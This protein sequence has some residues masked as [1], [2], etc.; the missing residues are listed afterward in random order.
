MMMWIIKKCQEKSL[1]I[2][3]D[4]YDW[5]QKMWF[6]KINISDKK[7]IGDCHRSIVVTR[8]RKNLY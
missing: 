8:R 3:S 7:N 1:V 2:L 4:Q 6:T 5:Q